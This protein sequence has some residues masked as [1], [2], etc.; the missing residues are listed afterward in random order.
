MHK[1]SKRRY[2]SVEAL[3]RDVDHYLK[4]EPLEAQRDTLNY[5]ARKFVR[6]NRRAVTAAALILTAVIAMA[7]FFTVRLA[8]AKNAALAEA[9]ENPAYPTFHAEFVRRRR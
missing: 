2:S 5:R 3:I 4:S 6:R 1:D 8:I 7:A 9:A